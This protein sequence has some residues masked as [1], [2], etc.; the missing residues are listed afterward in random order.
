MNGCH[1]TVAAYFLIKFELEIEK[2]PVEAEKVIVQYRKSNQAMMTGVAEMAKTPKRRRRIVVKVGSSSLTDVEG[3]ISIEKMQNIASQLARIQQMQ[4][5]E[6]VLVSSGA[7]AAGIGKLGWRRANMTM[8]EQQAAAS[9]GQMLLMETY[10]RLFAA[11]GITVGQVLLT[12]SDIEDRNRF[13]HIRDT[14]F[15]LMHN[16]VIPIVNEN[17]T[18]AVDE[19]RFGDNDTLASL[20]ALVCEADRL[21]LLTDIDGLY[22]G[23]PAIDAQAVKLGEVR[24]ITSEIEQIAGESGSSVGTGGM[25]TKI[26]AAKIAI[27]SGADVIIAASGERDVLLRICDDERVGTLIHGA[28]E[29]VARRKSWIAYGAQPEGALM[30][31]EGAEQALVARA[32]SVLLPGIVGIEGD[33]READVIDVKNLAGRVIGKGITNFSSHHLASLIGERRAGH[34]VAGAPEVIH[35]NDMVLVERGL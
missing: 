35:R 24:E 13:N 32:G 31:D 1:R 21:V 12:R 15:A 5:W 34:S 26:S 20:V 10:E 4:Q 8:P 11:K 28:A 33:F 23:N 29:P 14:L 7:I 6:I 22:T 18:V 3:R 25:R 30:V 2:F 27:Q 19:I 9:V 17:D 16:Q